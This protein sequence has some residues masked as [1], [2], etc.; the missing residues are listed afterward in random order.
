ML[1]LEKIKTLLYRE[2]YGII[3]AMIVFIAFA[4]GAVYALDPLPEEERNF[5]NKIE[6][7]LKLKR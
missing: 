2:E 6:N 5:I 7:N 4:V 1:N 3:F